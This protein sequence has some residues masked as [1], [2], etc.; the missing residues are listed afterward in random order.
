MKIIAESGS[1]KTEWV[2]LEN[3]RPM[4]KMQTQGFNPNYY[5][6]SVLDEGV[7]EVKLKT[8]RKRVSEIYFYGSGCT[9][10]E[11]K[12][13]VSNVLAKYFANAKIEVRNDLHAAALALFGNGPGIASIL[14]TGSSSCVCAA[15]TVVYQ[16]PSLGYQLGD[17][18]SGFHLGKLLVNAYFKS[19]MPRSIFYDFTEIFKFN[20][21]DF[22][23][24]YYTDPKPN[25]TLASFVP[26]INDHKH[27]PFI[28][29]LL[30]TAFRSFFSENIV[31][32]PYYEGFKLGFAGSVAYLF[33]EA[34]REVAKEYDLEI[35][36]IIQN[37]IEELVEYHVSEDSHF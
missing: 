20:L 1:T 28:Q 22:I 30:K 3:N 33:R 35:S 23:G 19:L 26:F 27:N 36:K 9:R 21:P 24:S 17:E 18:G 10:D 31:Y 4:Q 32:Y 6:A 13:I 12:T 11:S 37:P 8:K 5:P 34:L 2:L 7:A 15:G 29:K 14:G 25:A 16:L